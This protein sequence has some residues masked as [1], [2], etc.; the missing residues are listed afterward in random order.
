MFLLLSHVF[1]Y[2]EHHKINLNDQITFDGCVMF[3]VV[4]P[5]QTLPRCFRIPTQDSIQASMVQWFHAFLFPTGR[6]VY[7]QFLQ[8]KNFRRTKQNN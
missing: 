6:K 3:F 5:S 2:Y 8:Y 7:G 4:N 1:S